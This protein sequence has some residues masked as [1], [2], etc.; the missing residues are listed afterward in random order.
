MPKV[1]HRPEVLGRLG[2]AVRVRSD[3]RPYLPPPHLDRGRVD[4]RGAAQL[5]DMVPR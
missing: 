1:E 4:G 5:P 2:K 3:R